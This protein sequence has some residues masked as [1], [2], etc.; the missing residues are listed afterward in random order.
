MSVLLVDE[1]DEW[2]GG[3]N[4]MVVVVVVLEIGVVSEWVK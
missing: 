4:E 2:V 3:M 1:W